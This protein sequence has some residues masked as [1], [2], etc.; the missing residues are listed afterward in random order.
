M[1]THSE[2]RRILQMVADGEVDPDKA[3]LLL[4]ALERRGEPRPESSG[5]V[6]RVR[7]LGTFKALRIEGDPSVKGAVAEGPHRVRHDGDT[8]I[9]EDDS[10][11]EEASYVVFGPRHRG[12]TIRVS[13]QIG[14]KRFS[15]GNQAP[16]VRIRMNPEL[17]LEVELT[18]GSA[19]ITGI[20][21]PV[22][23]SLTAGTARF[24]GIRSPFT[25][26]I[27]AGSL[28]V[29][30]LF[31]DGDSEI[32][33]TAGKVDVDLEEGSNV[34]IRARATL[35]KISLPGGE[36]WSGIGGGEKEVTIGKGKGFLDL[37]ATTGKVTVREV[38]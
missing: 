24:E 35:G 14:D 33:C 19:R 8:F 9:I 3:A 32:R 7:V 21:A 22:K 5:E 23:A 11:A 1:E 2:K 36:D 15:W 17:P 10:D 20:T 30:G 18:A 38:S 34:R 37:E 26:G 6:A 25:A 29:K 27:E 4:A 13:G 16:A 28:R 12:R 31:D